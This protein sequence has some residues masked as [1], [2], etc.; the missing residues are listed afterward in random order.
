M[1][2]TKI[3]SRSGARSSTFRRT[4]PRRRYRRNPRLALEDDDFDAELLGLG[5]ERPSGQG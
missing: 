2:W 1:R 3:T 5:A 4:K